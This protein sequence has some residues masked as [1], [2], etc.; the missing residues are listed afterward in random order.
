MKK[1]LSTI[2]LLILMTFTNVPV[3]NADLD[4]TGKDGVDLIECIR[5]GKYDFIA[6]IN[7]SVSNENFV[8]LFTDRK[9]VV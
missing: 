3:V 7:A 2:S 6:F 9:S 4:D 8:E 5:K 1:Y